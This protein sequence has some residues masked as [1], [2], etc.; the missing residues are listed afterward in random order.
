MGKQTKQKKKISNTAR[1]IMGDTFSYKIVPKI[2]GSQNFTEF[3]KKSAEEIGRII[4]NM[5]TGWRNSGAP[6]AESSKS[7]RDAHY[8]RKYRAEKKLKEAKS[9]FPDWEVNEVI[10]DHIRELEAETEI[11]AKEYRKFMKNRD[12]DEINAPVKP[13]TPEEQEMLDRIAAEMADKVP[14]RRK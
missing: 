1:I 6:R 2:Q 10:Q 11:A 8:L 12:K 5:V 7:S 4:E 9:E 3:E 13:V 14:K